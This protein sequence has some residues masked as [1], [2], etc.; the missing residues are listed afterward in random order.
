LA[1]FVSILY[2]HKKVPKFFLEKLLKVKKKYRH[3]KIIKKRVCEHYGH[4]QFFQKV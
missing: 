2:L 4:N 1:F 3:K